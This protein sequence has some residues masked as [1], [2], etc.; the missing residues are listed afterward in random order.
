[1][2]QKRIDMATEIKLIG[3][4]AKGFRCPDH[5]V[6]LINQHGEPYHVT[7]IQMPNGTGKT[8]TLELLRLTL[9]GGAS[10]Q[11]TQYIR[12]FAK[13]EDAVAPGVMEVRL[14]VDKKVVT[15]VMTFDY[16]QGKASYKT[17]YRSGQNSGFVAP[18]E[19]K[20]F[21][22]PEFINY[23]ILD[24]ELAEKLLNNQQAAAQDVI[25]ALFQVDSLKK[26]GNRI[27]EY[28]SQV[29]AGVTTRTA[30]GYNRQK[31]LVDEI[32]NRLHILEQECTK[33]DAR[34][35]KLSTELAEQKSEH[36]A[37]I[38]NNR[39]QN[40]ELLNAQ[41][42]LHELEKEQISKT[43][44]LLDLCAS[45]QNLSGVFATSILNLKLGLDR[46]KLPEAAAR[47]F[48][49]EL[50]DEPE[51][52]CGREINPEIANTI[53]A[54]ASQYLGSDDV[55]LLNSLKTAIDEAVGQDPQKHRLALNDQIEGLTEKV[56][57]VNE[58]RTLVEELTQKASEIDPRVKQAQDEIERLTRELKEAELNRAK[59]D[60]QENP[61]QIDSIYG[62]DVLRSR[63]AEAEQYLAEITGTLAIRQKTAIIKSILDDAYNSATKKISTELVE[64]TNDNL[65]KWLPNNNLEVES[66]HGHL[67][68]KGKAKGSV[69]ENLSVAYGFLSTLFNRTTHSLPFIVDSPAGALDNTVRRSIGETI[70]QLTSQFVT[71][72]ISSERQKFI[73][74]GIEKATDDIQYITIFR[75]R[76]SDYLISAEKYEHTTISD[77]GVMVDSK[78]FFEHFDLITD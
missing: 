61:A 42:R 64:E 43:T 51:C 65:K 16:L 70:P 55:S 23:F 59:Y 36:Q 75:K 34:I 40:S 9:S 17:T 57:A 15:F 46:V 49:E 33:L 56:R 8:T 41:T 3:W 69:G 28:W 67:R 31:N 19:I 72:I 5:Q 38:E 47:E 53:R 7:L 18:Q 66:I 32:K 44:S 2:Q 6:E 10:N 62:L 63:L 50:C 77:D 21:L 25:D 12:S 22:N 27:E 11:T 68:L 58:A 60:S 48:F 78:E 14:L 71:F 35:Q 39:A 74:E 37:A 26:I 13:E 24:G 20:K 29:A 1:M 4:S 54:K 76:I 73:D 52:I 45:P 30:Q